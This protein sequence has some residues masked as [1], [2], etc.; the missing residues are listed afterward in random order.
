MDIQSLS[1]TKETCRRLLAQAITD[2]VSDNGNDIEE[3][4]KDAFGLGET[5]DEKCIRKIVNFYEKGGCS[6]FEPSGALPSILYGMDGENYYDK[7]YTGVTHT[8]YTCLYIVVDEKGM[9]RLKYHRFVNGGI[10]YDEDQ[11]EEEHGYVVDLP[12]LDI[13]YLFYTLWSKD[14]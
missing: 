8:N 6:F 3:Y 10:N 9:E 7:L 11:A 12:L 5:S 13:Y 14:L 4:E 2:F 1:Q